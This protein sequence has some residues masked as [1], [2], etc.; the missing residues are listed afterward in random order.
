MVSETPA[1]IAGTFAHC[2]VTQGPEKDPFFRRDT[3]TCT[4][5]LPEAFPLRI[6]TT[7]HVIPAAGDEKSVVAG[8]DPTSIVFD[9]EHDKKSAYP[10]T[11]SLEV[12]N[13]RSQ[14]PDTSKVQTFDGNLT[15]K[16]SVTIPAPT[17]EAVDLRLPYDFWPITVGSTAL[18]TFKLDARDTNVTPWTTVPDGDSAK[19][20]SFMDAVQKDQSVSFLALVPVGI[21]ELPVHITRDD[22]TLDAVFDGPGTYTM[23]ATGLMHGTGE[24]GGVPT[25]TPTS[26]GDAPAEAFLACHADGDSPDG[27]AVYCTGRGVENVKVHSFVVVVNGDDRRGSTAD[28]STVS[29]SVGVC[30]VKPCSLDVDVVASIGQTSVT[31]KFS[32]PLAGVSK[33]TP[34]ILRLPFDVW[35]ID[36]DPRGKK[37]FDLHL[38]TSSTEM[39]PE[40]AGSS[41]DQLVLASPPTTVIFPAP[42]GVATIAGTLRAIDAGPPAKVV[43]L[44]PFNV[45]RGKR[46]RLSDA[47]TIE[48]VP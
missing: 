21:K 3:V 45:E 15:L 8:K 35:S 29:S 24:A 17:S 37:L 22:R 26:F 42:L 14:L 13:G 30:V 27:Q 39:P 40:W 31:G 2:T 1:P 32:I 7:V 43:D 23:T 16:Q 41:L 18:G 5:T 20:A 11:L 34:A 9:A 38:A 36:I 12:I 48:T 33:D 4:S 44:P 47:F 46:Y 6:N 28:V 25:A 10:L 19:I